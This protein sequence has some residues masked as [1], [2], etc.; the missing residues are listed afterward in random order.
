MKEGSWGVR[1]EERLFPI[2]PLV[3]YYDREMGELP[4]RLL[5]ALSFLRDARQMSPGL[6][7]EAQGSLEKAEALLV[8]ALAKLFRQDPSR[9]E[10]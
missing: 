6:S 1:A 5:L 9:E 10:V 8:S 4:G 7:P 2:Y 3:E